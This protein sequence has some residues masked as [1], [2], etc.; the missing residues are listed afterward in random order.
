MPEVSATVLV[1]ADLET[2]YQAAKDIEGLAAFISDVESIKVTER[3]EL[4]GGLRVVARWVGLLP[5]FRRKIIWS[6][7]DHWD[8]AAHRCVYHLVEGDWDDYTGEWDFIETD[9]GIKVTLTVRYVYNVPLV[10]ALIQKLLLNKVQN[11][12]NKIQE[13]L[14]NRAESGG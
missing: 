14:K 2:V 5:E 10:G 13:G 12:T 6:E 11:S 3:E 4:E 8:D 7:E 1:N 9:E